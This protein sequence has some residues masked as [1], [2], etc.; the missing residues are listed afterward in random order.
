MLQLLDSLR[1]KP[2]QG[3]DL[4]CG[5]RKIRMTITSKGRGKAGGA[6]VITM[7][8][9][10]DVEKMIIALLYIYDKA[11]IANVSDAFLQ[12]IIK[13]LDM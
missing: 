11:E 3:V 10:V 9:N 12:Q 2:Y 5:I 8:V 13:E 4:G 7:N 1:K 6:R